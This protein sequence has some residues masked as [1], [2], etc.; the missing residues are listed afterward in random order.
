M[1]VEAPKARKRWPELA[2]ILLAL[3]GITGG[4]L[5]AIPGAAP[6]ASTVKAG[7]ELTAKGIDSVV[8]QPPALDGY[9]YDALPGC[10]ERDAGVK[11]EGDTVWLK[12]GPVCQ[13]R[14]GVW[15]DPKD[16]GSEDCK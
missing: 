15:V 9:R 16:G 2:A 7:I 10:G 4:V 12:S 13:C 5:S 1:Q 11:G 14:G 8:E 6:W 3:G